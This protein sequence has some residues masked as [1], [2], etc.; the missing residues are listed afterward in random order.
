[1]ELNR[2]SHKAAA[3]SQSVQSVSQSVQSVSLFSHSVNQQ[4]ASIQPAF[5]QQLASPTLTYLQSELVPHEEHYGVDAIPTAVRHASQRLYSTP[6]A[7]PCSTQ[8][9]HTHYIVKEDSDGYTQNEQM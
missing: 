4:S 1:M 6:P 3:V 8:Q 9:P 5:S 2:T 7:A